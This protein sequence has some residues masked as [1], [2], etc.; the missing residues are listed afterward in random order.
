MSLHG[1]D[2]DLATLQA[3]IAELTGII[4][5]NAANRVDPNR[6]LREYTA[7][8]ADDIHLGYTTPDIRADEYQINP[9]W[10]SSIQRTLFHGYLNEDAVQHLANFEELCLTQKVRTISNDDLKRMTFTFTLADKA[11]N[12]IRS[13]RPDNMDT[14]AK[15]SNAFLN[16]FFPP[17]KTDGIRH[18]I[19]NFRQ[20]YDET[21]ADAWDRFNELRRSCPHHGIQEWSLLRIFYG[22]LCN[23]DRQI[24]DA[25]AGGSLCERHIDEGFRLIDSMA[26]NQTQFHKP[27]EDLA[28][29]N[30][31][32]NKVEGKD[33]LLE[34][35]A[36]LKKQIA[37]LAVNSVNSNPSPPNSQFIPAIIVVEMIICR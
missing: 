10:I 11:K 4:N 33:K 13:Q 2:E 20:E 35:I 15:I 3:R 18:Q 9:A 27:R 6:P 30:A 31:K 17:G 28:Y 1:D 5:A 32:M 22:G 34:E 26:L 23:N 7:P 16:K 37:N 19:H 8:R 29:I 14:W 12:W 36:E 24:L 21:L 25:A